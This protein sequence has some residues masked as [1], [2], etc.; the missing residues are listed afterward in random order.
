M[1]SFGPFSAQVM[2]SQLSW[3]K[4][5]KIKVRQSFEMLT[6][7]SEAEHLAVRPKNPVAFWY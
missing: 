6:N 4:P 2:A 1:I 7:L 3:D 5:S